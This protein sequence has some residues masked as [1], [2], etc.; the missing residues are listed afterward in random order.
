MPTQMNQW[1]VGKTLVTLQLWHGLLILLSLSQQQQAGWVGHTVCPWK[2]FV[3]I[4]L[5]L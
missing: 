1:S 4:L 3:R 5:N 2:D